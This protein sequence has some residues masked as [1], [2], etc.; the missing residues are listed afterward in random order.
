MS[1]A[2]DRSGRSGGAG[3][4]NAGASNGGGSNGGGSPKV[5]LG[6][7]APW[8]RRGGSTGWMPARPAAGDRR[9]LVG[10][11]CNDDVRR[12]Y[13]DPVDVA[14]LQTVAELRHER[15]EVASGLSGPAK[16]DETAES[17]LA[18]FTADL[19]VLIVG[20]GCPFV[21]HVVLEKAPHL[22]MLGELEGDR[23]G[24]HF[25]LAAA[26]AHQVRIVDTTHG[27]SWPT[28]E[29]ALALGLLGLRN[30]GAFFRRLID[31]RPA[32]PS[33]REPRT[34]W[35]YEGGELSHK[36]VGMI[37]FGHLGRHLTRLLAPF[38]VDVVAY[39]PFACRDLA[40]AYGVVFGPLDVVL[41]ADVVFCLLPLTPRTERLL[42]AEQLA[43]L[44]PRSVFVNVS[45]GRVVDSDALIERVSHGDVVACLDVFDPE[46]IPLD[47][48]VRDLENVFLSPHLGG[49]GEE[50]RRRFFALMVDECLRHLA[51]LEP[52]DEL[53]A[54]VV[55]L[56]TKA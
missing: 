8:H 12:R 18:S 46:P 34:G 7:P 9:P 20:H 30:A 21:S 25:D 40:E 45:R 31:H 35:G 3:A 53:T 17:A 32:F 54:A 4:S 49:V 6:S 42:G 13:V 47:S 10:L 2:N 51:G 48:P 38:E 23:F 56:R 52:Y 43:L 24:Y 33:G 16:R 37:G 55:E 44:R 22:S 50:S 14:R 41:S 36:R 1:A 11:A 26:S 29:W 27:S 5:S 28:A 19:D 39:D 15:F